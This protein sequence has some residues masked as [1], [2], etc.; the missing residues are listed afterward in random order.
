[1]GW[2][3]FWGFFGVEWVPD[4]LD[5]DDPNDPRNYDWD[6]DTDPNFDFHI[7]SGTDSDGVPF[8]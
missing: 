8:D 4:Q 1:M 5:R 7:P 6:S 2:S 3:E